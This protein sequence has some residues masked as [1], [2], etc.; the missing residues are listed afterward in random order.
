VDSDRTVNH[1]LPNSQ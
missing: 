1:G